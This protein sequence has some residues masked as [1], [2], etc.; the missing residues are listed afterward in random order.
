MS[1]SVKR[2]YDK[3]K[4]GD[5]FR[6]LV[7]RLWPRGVTKEKLKIDEWMKEIAPSP[8]LRQWYG[9]EV[10]KWPEFRKRYRAELAKPPANKLLQLLAERSQRGKVT[11]VIGARDVEHANGAVIAEMIEAKKSSKRPKSTRST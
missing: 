10:E 1:V 4:P 8:E 7:D 2:A 11:L 9:H 5:G 3:A 6:V